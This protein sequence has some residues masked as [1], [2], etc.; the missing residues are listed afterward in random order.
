[1]PKIETVE[2]VPHSAR[3][4]YDLVADVENY[5]E[6]VPLCQSLT[7]LSNRE[8]RGRHVIEARMQVGYK[9]I[10]E[11]F[12]S[13]VVLRPD[14]LKIDVS[15]IDGPFEYLDNNWTFIPVDDHCCDIDFRL[16]YKFRNRGLALLMGSV[17]DRAFARVVAAFRERADEIYGVGGSTA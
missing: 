10:R 3:A 1:M 14:E 9:S 5:P 6:F 17:F 7:V 12:V 11:T 8:R 15:Y 2:R 13:R 4:M 16:D